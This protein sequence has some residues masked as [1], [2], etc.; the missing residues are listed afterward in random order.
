[1][2]VATA[3]FDGLIQVLREMSYVFHVFWLFF[4]WTSYQLMALSLSDGCWFVCN[5]DCGQS[6]LGFS[7]PLLR[8]WERLSLSLFYNVFHQQC[9]DL[10]VLSLRM[11]IKLS[12]QFVCSRCIFEFYSMCTHVS[13]WEALLSASGASMDLALLSHSAQAGCFSVDESN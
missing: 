5:C 12:L 2:C 13:V 10:F 9:F 11:S 4:V 6:D 3:V 1:M 8:R 7:L